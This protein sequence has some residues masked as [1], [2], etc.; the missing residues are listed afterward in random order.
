MKLVTFALS[1]VLVPAALAAQSAT[2][3]IAAAGGA[4][5][6]LGSQCRPAKCNNEAAH[7]QIRTDHLGADPPTQFGAPASVV[8]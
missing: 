3:T 4:S 7:C 2:T 5:F 1:I 6:G 8:K